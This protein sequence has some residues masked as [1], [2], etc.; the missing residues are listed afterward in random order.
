MEKD[1][2]D[3]MHRDMSSLRMMEIIENAL[4]CRKEVF[5]IIDQAGDLET[6]GTKLAEFFNI[7]EHESG[8]ILNL[9]ARMWIRSY[10]SQLA[11]EI[12]RLKGKIYGDQF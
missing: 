12:Q 10:R 6:A 8:V 11:E 2:S 1:N 9:S 4:N 7:Q 5:E 3:G